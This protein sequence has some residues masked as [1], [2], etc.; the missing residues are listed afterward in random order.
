MFRYL[1]LSAI[2]LTLVGCSLTP[3]QP[4]AVGALNQQQWRQHSRALEPINKWELTGKLGLRSPAQSGSAML[5]W[6]QDKNYFDIRL[7]GPLGQGATRLSGQPG[8]VRLDISS[9]GSFVSSSAEALMQHELGWSLPVE[10]LLSWAK[11]L[12]VKKLAFNA[13]YDQQSRLAEL[14]QAGWKIE[15]LDYQSDAPGA[16]PTRMKVQGNQLQLTLV[17]KEWNASRAAK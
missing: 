9:K 5:T 12:P 1:L 7:N 10:Y 8:R 14:N 16:L 2:A 15:Y 6:Y 3:Q 17:I 11:G 13:Q 4:D